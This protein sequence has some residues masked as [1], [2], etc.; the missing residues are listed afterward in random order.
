MCSGVAGRPVRRSLGGGGS[1]LTR[2]RRPAASQGNQPL[3]RE[4]QELRSHFP[5][6]LCDGY[7]VE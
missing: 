5:G 7:A 6:E 4:I 2:I 1:L 3:L